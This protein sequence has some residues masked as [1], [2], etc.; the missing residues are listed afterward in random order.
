LS[1]SSVRSEPLVTEPLEPPPTETA[2]EAALAAGKVGL[3]LIPFLGGALAE[4]LGAIVTPIVERRRNEWFESLAEGFNDLRERVDDLDAHLAGDEVF[5]TTVLT[6]TQAAIRD[7]RAEKMEALRNAVLNSALPGAPDEF[8]QATFLRLV[9][10]LSP[11]HLRML[12]IVD[13]PRHWFDQHPE[14]RAPEFGISSSIGALIEAAI[15]DVAGRRDI[16]DLVAKELE[17]RNLVSLPLHTTM[18][19]TG[20]WESH[21]NGLGQQFLAFISAPT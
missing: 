18:T 3:N 6:A 2:K 12:T 4:T 21:T 8:M 1:S 16:Y 20:A 13:N 7:G 19:A 15:P 14:L 17:D 9:D 5:A 10:E 11:I